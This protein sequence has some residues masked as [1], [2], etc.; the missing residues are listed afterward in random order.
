[1]RYLDASS[2][3]PTNGMATES[4]FFCVTSVSLDAICTTGAMML[5][6]LSG[7]SDPKEV[8]GL[9]VVVVVAVGLDLKN[10]WIIKI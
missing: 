5:S 7:R 1:M 10:R 9:I 4:R 3:A 2:S 6:V 8:V